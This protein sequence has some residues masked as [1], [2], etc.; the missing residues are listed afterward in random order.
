[1]MCDNKHN[2]RVFD[3]IL[4]F[5]FQ[6][7]PAFR[8]MKAPVFHVHELYDKYPDGCDTGCFSFVITKFTFY[9]YDNQLR[10]WRPVSGSSSAGS[11]VYNVTVEHPLSAGYY[12]ANQARETV[13]DLVRGVG[14]IITY[15]VGVKQWIIEQ[16]AGTSV[17]G[18]MDSS[19]WLRLHPSGSG[20][21]E[22]V[23]TPTPT[24][25]PGDP[26]PPD[27]ATPPP[28]EEPNDPTPAP[29]PTPT[30][31]P[32][33]AAPTPEAPVAYLY[34]FDRKGGSDQ[35]GAV[36]DD[37]GYYPAGERIG[38]PSLPLVKDGCV[39]MGY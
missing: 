14:M 35:P 11:S 34:T 33:P 20:G 37:T 7:I 18:W 16:Y 15:A 38:S 31:Y 28:E 29:Q 4:L 13:P 36:G 27:E 22:P 30:P 26:N 1:M 12:T 39:L 24:P 10:Y 32:T 3:D 8:Y 5:I 25:S 9:V 2:N 23:P 17:A 21:G 6:R 19:N